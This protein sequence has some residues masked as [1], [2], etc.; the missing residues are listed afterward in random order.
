MN[1]FAV[2]PLLI[3][4][5][6]A[7]YDYRYRTGV[8]DMMRRLQAWL[9]DE[10]GKTWHICPTVV[11]PS[12]Q[13]MEE[14][15]NTNIYFNV[16]EQ[17]REEEA[18][19][20]VRKDRRGEPIDFCN[21]KRLYILT[22]IGDCKLENMGGRSVFGCAP[23]NRNPLEPWGPGRAG[24]P[25][26]WAMELIAGHPVDTRPYVADP[27]LKPLDVTHG[28]TLHETCHCLG[29]PHPAEDVDGPEA[30]LSPMAG[31]WLFGQSDCHLLPREKN[32]LSESPFFN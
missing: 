30:W 24:G 7:T 28:A 13:T 12:W 3:V 22:A 14:H 26:A 17:L 18:Q 29:V 32:Q 2:T 21:W 15:R 16:A 31:Y 27:N 5:K 10:V 4:S 23:D 1:G 11:I 6:D 20:F 19:G 8:D 25:S 9:F